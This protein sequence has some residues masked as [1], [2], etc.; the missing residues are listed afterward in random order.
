M[1][2]EV[3][4]RRNRHGRFF[5][6]A[7]GRQL[8]KKHEFSNLTLNDI[9]TIEAIDAISTDIPLLLF[10]QGTRGVFEKVG[11]M[12]QDRFDVQEQ[13]INVGVLATCAF[14]VEIK[15]NVFQFLSAFSIGR[16]RR[17]VGSV[18]VLI[19]LEI[20][21]VLFPDILLQSLPINEGE[22]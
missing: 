7:K 16:L 2:I 9:R 10:N 19:Q 17:E 4:S 22:Q 11:I 21:F 12:Q 15:G 6:D 1:I 8:N 5:N 13:H 3:G 14:F 20:L 18:Q